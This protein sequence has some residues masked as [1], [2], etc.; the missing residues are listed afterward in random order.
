MSYPEFSSEIMPTGIHNIRRH[1]VIIHLQ[2]GFVYISSHEECVM[3]SKT[4]GTWI[5]TDLC[6]NAQYLFIVFRAT[7]RQRS[8]R[9]TRRVLLALSAS[10]VTKGLSLK[11]VPR[12]TLQ[13]LN[14]YNMQRRPSLEI[15]KIF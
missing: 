11:S 5:R 7:F 1:G 13:P 3:G 9:S 2:T 4:S 10:P 8:T 14:K 15:L 12:S 6:T